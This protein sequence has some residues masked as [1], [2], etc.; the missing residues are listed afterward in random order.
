MERQGSMKRVYRLNSQQA[1][2]TD[3]FLSA[4]VPPRGLPSGCSG[5]RKS[6]SLS[7]GSIDIASQTG[8]RHPLLIGALQPKS[9]HPRREQVFGKYGP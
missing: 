9:L 1:V 2:T 8:P 7:N 4:V 5:T 3:S 6:S